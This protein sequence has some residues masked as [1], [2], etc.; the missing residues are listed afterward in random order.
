M[1]PVLE[2]ILVVS[3]LYL[4]FVVARKAWKKA[5]VAAKK[6]EILLVEEQAEDIK[7][8]SKSHKASAK[9]QEVL[10]DFIKN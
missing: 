7:E 3:G 8:F 4:I 9:K 10:D 6:E 1:L 5:D 2:L